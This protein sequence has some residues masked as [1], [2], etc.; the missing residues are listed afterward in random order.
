MK[1]YSIFLGHRWIEDFREDSSLFADHIRHYLL[2]LI[3]SVLYFDL[4]NFFIVHFH[5]GIFNVKKNIK[6]VEEF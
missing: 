4:F 1:R 5:I 3:I 6:I 2:I